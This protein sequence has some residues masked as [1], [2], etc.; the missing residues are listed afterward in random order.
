MHRRILN[1]FLPV[2][3]VVITY[4]LLTG[5][6]IFLNRSILQD[7]T[8]HLEIR[9]GII[10]IIAAIISLE[11]L[12]KFSGIFRFFRLLLPFLLLAYLYKETDYLNN[13][14]FRNDLDPFFAGIEFSIFGFQPSLAFAQRFNSDFF[15]ELMYFGYF[16]YYL[17][18]FFVPAWLY[19][20]VKHNTG[21]SVSFIIIN[22][23][24]V[25]YLIFIFLPVAGPQFYF[26]EISETLPKGYLFGP[27]IRFIQL[28][29]EGH[30][31]AFPSSHVSI[32][33]MLLWACIKN[34]RK[35]LI[36]VIPVATLLIFSTVYIQAHYVIDIIAG[37]IFTP[38]LY[39]ISDK[40]YTSLTK[41]TFNYQTA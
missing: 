38:V 8:L 10:A 39:F 18:V 22:S 20:K 12:Y 36:F 31:A 33:L 2:E 16:S 15:A 41:Q 7:Y 13:L 1:T 37:F 32:C 29:G 40:I 27:I 6:L 4:L 35:L 30:T 28:N 3:L 34:A 21:E 25:Y 17:L 24:L 9:F 23:F 19:F 26:K 5:I 11:R 14:I